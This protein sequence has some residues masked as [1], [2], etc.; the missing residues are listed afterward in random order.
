MSDVE[1][2]PDVEKQLVHV[3]FRSVSFS[4]VGPAPLAAAAFLSC[5]SLFCHFMTMS[6]IR[7]NLKDMYVRMVQ[8]KAARMPSNAARPAFEML[9]LPNQKMAMRKATVLVMAPNHTHFF[10]WSCP[11][12]CNTL[13]RTA[14]M[15]QPSIASRKAIVKA[16]MLNLSSAVV[17]AI[18]PLSSPADSCTSAI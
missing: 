5:T 7:R 6:F 8:A 12:L 13:R 4:T 1:S 15:T 11:A 3:A 18:A 14:T 9:F 2:V 16:Y 10:M 17:G